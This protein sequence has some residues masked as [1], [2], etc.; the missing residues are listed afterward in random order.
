MRNI[1]D[2]QARYNRWKNGERYWDI[3][4]V[5]L[6]RYDT[7]DKNT[8]VTDD[9]SVFNVDHSAI[10]ARNLE[11]TTPEVEVIGK[12]QYPYQSSFNPYAL[13]EGIQY[14]LGNTVGKVMEPISKIPGVAPVLRTLTPSN[15]IGTLRTGIPMWDEKNPGFGD[16]YNDKQ[17][18]TLFDLGM[19]VAPFHVNYGTPWQ[20]LKYAKV[21]GRVRGVKVTGDIYHGSQHPFDISKARTSNPNTGDSGFHVGDTNEPTLFIANNIKGGVQYKGKLQ[22]KEPAFEVPDFERWNPYQFWSYAKENKEFANYLQKHGLSIDDFGRMS[23]KKADGVQQ[24]ADRLKNSGIA[25]KYK[26]KYETRTGNGYSYYLT[27][28]KQAHFTEVM[29]FKKN[30][31]LYNLILD[32][33]KYFMQ[34]PIEELVNGTQYQVLPTVKYTTIH[35]I[36]IVN[37]TAYEKER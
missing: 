18:N 31:K 25:L 34:A 2:F 5:D 17:I 35:P 22:L 20:E 19:S 28:P 12:K 26:N 4:G 16:S 27:N 24:L 11:V 1:K 8:V 33:Y 21:G 36:G 23:T 14:A 29:P 6:P 3:R 7:G 37:K 15:W 13:T 9:G 10:G 32:P 30:E